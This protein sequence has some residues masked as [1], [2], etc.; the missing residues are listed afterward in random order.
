MTPVTQ[1]VIAESAD[2]S[3]GNEAIFSIQGAPRKTKRKLGRKV[4]QVVTACDQVAM[5]FSMCETVSR[6]AR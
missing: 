1:A 3:F 5:N 2:A 6:R 4:T